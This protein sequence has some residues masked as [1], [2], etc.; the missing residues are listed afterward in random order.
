VPQGQTLISILFTDALAW[1]WVLENPDASAQVFAF[2]PN[3]IATAVNISSNEVYTDKLVAYQPDTY[4]GSTGTILSVYLAYIPASYVDALSAAIK[5]PNSAFYTKSFGIPLQ[6]SKVVNPTLPVMAY[7]S[8][9]ISSSAVETKDANGNI[10]NTTEVDNSSSEEKKRKTIII[11]VVTSI[12][13][14][15]LGLLSFFAFKRARKNSKN[16][17][18][19]SPDMQNHLR[20]LQL[21]GDRGTNAHSHHMM[22]QHPN[23]RSAYMP[24]EYSHQQ[25]SQQHDNAYAFP[26]GRPYFGAT[27]PASH[28]N[29]FRI[30][31]GS[32]S[33]G[34]SEDSHEMSSYSG[35]SD[36]HHQ[37]QQQQQQSNVI[38]NRQDRQHWTGP[39]R[40]HAGNTS[41]RSSSIDFNS[42]EGDEVR[43]SWWRFS[44]GFGRAF[45]SP[46]QVMNTV[47]EHPTSSSHHQQSPIG[48]ATTAASS[49]MSSTF[50]GASRAHVRNSARRVN[51]Q[52]GPRGDLS[53]AISRPQMQENSLML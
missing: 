4:D 8:Q 31:S 17:G 27:V 43:N 22:S 52:R 5:A 42:V 26:A 32:S 48:G 25:D 29:P 2:M 24:N 30:S 44:D 53:S 16:G 18:N 7:A 21:Q 12:G 34:S 6:L 45:S 28:Q 33:N 46:N 41:G 35:S 51:I 39:R 10:V 14:F 47:H 49:H 13:I 23:S 36:D 3:L 37:Q 38:Y 50:G 1:G 20:G 19:R 11:A 9:G 15:V 40:G